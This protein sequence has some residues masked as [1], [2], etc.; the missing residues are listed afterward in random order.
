MNK[1]INIAK[2]I[3]LLISFVLCS[4]VIIKGISSDVEAYLFFYFSALIIALA[5]FTIYM[6]PYIKKAIPIYETFMVVLFV[7]SVFII[8]LLLYLY[9]NASFNVEITYDY[10]VSAIVSLILYLS[11]IFLNIFFATNGLKNETNRVNDVLV[12]VTTVVAIVEFIIYSIYA[13][14]S[15]GLVLLLAVSYSMILSIQ[16]SMGCP[17]EATGINKVNKITIFFIL[18]L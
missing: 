8:G 1:R 18:A 3:G 10:E 13:F 16:V 17:H 15:A 5:M 2:L 6:K 14:I 11:F 7:A 12:L 9:F 4:I